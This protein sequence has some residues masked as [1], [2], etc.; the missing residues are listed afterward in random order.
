MSDVLTEARPAV[1]AAKRTWVSRAL[2]VAMEGVTPS[3]GD[4][5]LRDL[6]TS[7]L[8]F[9]FRKARLEWAMARTKARADLERL[10]G[11]LR[12][13]LKGHPQFT[14][15][16]QGIGKLS[17]AL[18]GL[19]DRLEDELDAALNTTDPAKLAD[20]K[21]AALKIIAE[22]QVVV[23]SDPLLLRMDSNPFMKVAVQAVLAN[24]LA[25]MARELAA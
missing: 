23:D 10:Q 5:P 4:D 20:S 15:M 3:R 19:D 17:E 21:K 11:G 1:S 16:D 13:A 8:S 24:Q 6:P 7:G 9:A 18:A 2:G 14:A 12:D 25:A 22:Y